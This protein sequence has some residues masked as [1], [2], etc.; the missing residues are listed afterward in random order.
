MAQVLLSVAIAF[1]V[2]AFTTF[3]CRRHALRPIGDLPMFHHLVSNL[4]ARPLRS[5]RSKAT[6]PRGKS[7]CR[8]LIESLEPRTLMS[9]SPTTAYLQTNLIS[10]QPGVAAITDASLVNPPKIL[11]RQFSHI[12]D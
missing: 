11:L 4:A 1:G 10:D 6:P 5:R 3:T 2:Q 8:L 9:A 7:T 12:Y